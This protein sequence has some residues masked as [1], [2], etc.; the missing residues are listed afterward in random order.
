VFNPIEKTMTLKEQLIQELD[1]V[2]EPLLVEVL[3]FLQFIKA[4]QEEEHE[5]VQDARAA[6]ARVSTEG[7][8]AWNDLKAEIGL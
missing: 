5:D 8:V 4:K 7:T 2:S 3:D 1:N 6:I